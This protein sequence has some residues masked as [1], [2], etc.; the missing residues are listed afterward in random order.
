MATKISENDL[1]RIRAFLTNTGGRALLA[2]LREPDIRPKIRAANVQPHEVQMDA[3]AQMG[4][5]KCLEEIEKF[6]APLSLG[7]FEDESPKLRDTRASA[8]PQK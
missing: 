5:D 7:D 4:Y 8:K 3:G 6:A 2:R 1:T